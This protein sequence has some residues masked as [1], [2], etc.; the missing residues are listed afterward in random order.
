MEI[1]IYFI[2]VAIIG[3]IILAILDY[4]LL[5]KFYRTPE[6][7]SIIASLSFLPI[8]I[9]FL[10]F[11][12]QFE[13]IVPILAWLSA[14]LLAF[15][16]SYAYA[17]S[18]AFKIPPGT[19]LWIVKLQMVF[20]F[21]V[22]VFVFWESLTPMQLLWH[23]VIFACAILLSIEHIG[24]TKKKSLLIFP[25]ISALAISWEVIILDIAY[26]HLHFGTIFG[27][28]AFWW[29]IGAPILILGT[30]NGQEFYKKLPTTWKKYLLIGWAV[31]LI[32]IITVFFANLALKFGPLS[33]V[34]FLKE[35]YVAFL[36]LISLIAGYYY[37]KYFPDGWKKISFKKLSIVCIMMIWV[38]LA[39]K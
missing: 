26:E 38:Y 24:L 36:I 25:L 14:G 13:N 8:W 6:T 17:Y 39:L 23:G 32:N 10:F 9:Y 20:A 1:W 34:V 31:E 2:A 5:H 16:A 29:F 3:N 11:D 4:N 37:P 19:T 28:F 18:Y 30:K 7:P 33:L 21:I 12:F 22:G 35:T 27:S 15:L